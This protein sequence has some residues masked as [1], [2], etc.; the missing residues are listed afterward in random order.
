MRDWLKKAG[1]KLAPGIG[2]GL[3]V[4]LIVYLF[5]T[6]AWPWVY[7][8]SARKD[9]NAGKDAYFNYE[10]AEARKLFDSSLDKRPNYA[11]A[12][13]A[14]GQLYAVWTAHNKFM[15][16]TYPEEYSKRAVYH[17]MKALKEKPN[18]LESLRAVTYSFTYPKRL[19]YSKCKKLYSAAEKKKPHDP[20]LLYIHWVIEGRKVNSEADIKDIEKALKLKRGFLPAKMDY[21]HALAQDGKKAKAEKSLIQL[22]E[23][24]TFNPN[25]ALAHMLR[26]IIYSR[27]GR[28][29][30]AKK[31]LEKAKALDD[32]A[33]SIYINLGA[34]YYLEKD[35]SQAMSLF[36]AALGIAPNLIEAYNNLGVIYFE[37]KD[38]DKAITSFEVGLG[39]KP[40]PELY[41]GLALA[42]YKKGRKELAKYFL[43]KAIAKREIYSTNAWLDHVQTEALKTH[44]ELLEQRKREK[45][46]N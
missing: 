44:K 15:G 33:A 43:E 1:K 29:K 14:L 22:H 27:N 21:A 42:Y 11:A 41:A 26:G 24:L 16:K 37:T 17:A 25:I 8:Y 32:K 45:S 3:A 13:A 36:K 20:E 35:F 39:I 6:Y 10:F 30:E 34:V 9:H 31:E 38:F 5:V 4:A 46:P 7:F 40:H 23:A 19:D 18:R 2:T 28:Q 12:H